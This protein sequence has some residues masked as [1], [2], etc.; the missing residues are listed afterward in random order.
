MPSLAV[1]GAG[2]VGGTLAAYL[3]LSGAD[4]TLIARGESF[5]RIRE[6]G[7]VLR[8]PS[9]EISVNV[10][11]TEEVEERYDVVVYATKSYQLPS[12]AEMVRS[13]PSRSSLHV[14]LQNGLGNEE[15]LK[16][17]FG[18]ERC[19]T[20]VIYISKLLW[21]ASFNPVT[22]LLDLSIG[23]VVKNPHALEV[24]RSAAEE[25]LSLARAEGIE[26]NEDVV[27]KTIEATVRMGGGA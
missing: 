6:R 5:R 27:D 10:R 8:T 16:K 19:S 24:V 7:A 13:T 12:A 22:A 1:V 17:Y 23:E 15:V 26:M 21:N 4:V 9:A 14:C 11:C 18:E 3:T 2:A 25:V 20:G